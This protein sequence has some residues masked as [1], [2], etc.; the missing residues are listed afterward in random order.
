MNSLKRVEAKLGEDQAL[1]TRVDELRTAIN[2][3]ASG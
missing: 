2:S 1:S 3:P